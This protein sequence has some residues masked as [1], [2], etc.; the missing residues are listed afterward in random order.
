MRPCFDPVKS[1]MFRLHLICF[2]F[3]ILDMSNF[4]DTA[5]W[6]CITAAVLVMGFK[7]EN[8]IPDS[9]LAHD[10]IEENNK[11]QWISQPSG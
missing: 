11:T 3:Q 4:V 8:Q 6:F 1:T 5:I 10:V 2:D 7:D 9:R